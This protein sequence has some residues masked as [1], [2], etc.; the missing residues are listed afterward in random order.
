MV[1][2]TTTEKGCK[3]ALDF[4]IPWKKGGGRNGDGLRME[5]GEK[6]ARDDLCSLCLCRGKEKGVTGRCVG[7]GHSFYAAGEEELVCVG[8]E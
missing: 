6:I 7:R 4:I 3:G 8:E 1:H 2:S 5:G